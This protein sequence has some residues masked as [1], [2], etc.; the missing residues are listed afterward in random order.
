MAGQF[1]QHYYTKLKSIHMYKKKRC[2]FIYDDQHWLADCPLFFESFLS[3][4]FFEVDLFNDQR[5]ARNCILILSLLLKLQ[6]IHK[7]LTEEGDEDIQHRTKIFQIITK[8]VRSGISLDSCWKACKKGS[9]IPLVP[10]TSCY[11]AFAVWFWI[12]PGILQMVT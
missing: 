8:F 10:G 6:C 1:L 9:L 5:M 3:K 2:C 11:G 12:S 7:I 4:L